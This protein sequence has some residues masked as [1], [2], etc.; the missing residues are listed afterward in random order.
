MN[1]VP[2]FNSPG[3]FI[4]ILILALAIYFAKQA[5]AIATELGGS[6]NTSIGDNLR[7][8]V[9]GLWKSTKKNAEKIRDIIRDRKK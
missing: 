9:K 3:F 7:N 8:D 4:T 1:G 2:H 5:E 6:I